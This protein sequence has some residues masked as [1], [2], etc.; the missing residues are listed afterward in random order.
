MNK[1]RLLSGV[2]VAVLSCTLTSVV[3]QAGPVRS[4][5]YK[6][7]RGIQVSPYDLNKR[8]SSSRRRS[9][10][11][12]SISP[13]DGQLPTTSSSVV[14]TQSGSS[15]TSIME[16]PST[17]SGVTHSGPVR[18]SRH[19]IVGDLR[20]GESIY[21]QTSDKNGKKVEG[22]G[23]RPH[24]IVNITDSKYVSNSVEITTV[25]MSRAVGKEDKFDGNRIFIINP[26]DPGFSGNNSSFVKLNRVKKFTY[27]K[28]FR[29]GVLGRVVNDEDM[30]I[31]RQRLKIKD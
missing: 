31:I 1:L 29:I 28:D 9:P 7:V 10:S 22:A 24:L 13:D 12:S 27:K 16:G 19:R 26:S 17:S 14:V 23:P 15:N 20:V 18:T 8:S 30:K 4:V 21:R 11:P 25:D 6:M 2:P 3:V 5:V